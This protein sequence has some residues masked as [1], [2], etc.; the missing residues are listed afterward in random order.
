MSID[1]AKACDAFREAIQKSLGYAPAKI[2]DDGK[3]HRFNTSKKDNSGWY[4]FYDD[5]P[6]PAGA[7]GDWRTSERE[8]WSANGSAG[9]LSP[10]DRK[11]VEA[12]KAKRER[13]E[14]KRQAQAAETA[15]KDWA[16]AKPASE[17]HP[18]L[19]AK[20][21]RPHGIRE[22]EGK[23]LIPVRIERGM[24]S[25]QMINP[26]GDKRFL[27][28]GRVRGGYFSIGKIG[29]TIIICEG[30]ATGATLYE[31]F[32][33]PVVVA[34]NAGNLESVAKTIREKYPKARI[35]IAADDDFKTERERGF[36]TGIEK[37]RMAAEAVGGVF[38]PPPFDR[39][40]DAK[41]SDWNDLACTRGA[42]AMRDAFEAAC[43]VEKPPAPEPDTDDSSVIDLAAVRRRV[44]AAGDK[45]A[46]TLVELIKKV[47]PENRDEIIL[48]KVIQFAARRSKIK[49]STIEKR[50]L[51][52]VRATREEARQP[53]PLKCNEKGR[54][55]SCLT[56]CL[57]WIAPESSRLAFNEMTFA[58]EIDGRPMTDDDFTALNITAENM[59]GV[60]V[61]LGH[62]RQATV[63]LR[64]R[65]P[66]HPIRSYLQGLERDATFDGKPRLDEWLTT[67][68][69]VAKTS[70][71]QAIGKMFLIS[72]IAR[73]FEPGCKADYLL[74]LEGEQG[75]IKSTVCEILAGAE[76]FS[77][78][79]PDIATAGK[80]VSVHLLGKWLIEIAE[81][82][83]MSRADDKLLKSFLSRKTEKYRPP[84]LRLE[85]AQPRHGRRYWPAKVG[86]IKVEDLRRDR[87]LLFAEAVLEYR[88]GARW[89]PDRAFE[90]E[91]IK[92]EQD[93]RYED[94]PWQTTIADFLLA[95]TETY[96]ASIMTHLGI[97]TPKKDRSAQN[98]IIAIL[99]RL[100]W[101]R[102]GHTEYG[103]K[104]I[105]QS[106]S[107]PSAVRQPET[108]EF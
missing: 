88:K 14:A 92:P 16:K 36:N 38:A 59:A 25:L 34:F 67:Y 64:L 97:E 20:G 61:S 18:Y 41:S 23:L 19:G 72:M 27:T 60:P 1:I 50:I 53:S 77:D 32:G 33:L 105:R 49:P 37:G 5:P 85:T 101:V 44:E 94:D 87:D 55:L 2:I 28:D 31:L 58:P 76:Y 68:L 107:G 100:R 30:Y 8:T 108:V 56:N 47:P 35:I 17:T 15:K 83:A 102:G 42:D 65:R 11:L 9:K 96:V 75:L 22:C 103:T 91:Q 66:H 13:E 90:S 104:W 78:C 80:D 10:A 57:I 12:L 43:R 4:C 54:P 86:E 45:A 79:L 52:D 26:E 6:I 81:L 89:W 39:E 69:G 48:A 99:T 3:I 46:E 73:I 24:T 84:Y 7:F 51:R 95:K 70:Y 21:V 71:S 29:A 106:V 63:S 93:A 74:V 40:Q 82:H 98:R 62:V